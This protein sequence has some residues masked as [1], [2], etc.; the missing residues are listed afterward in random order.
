MKK[1]IEGF[2]QCPYCQQSFEVIHE[3]NIKSLN[4]TAI[5]QCSCDEFPVFDGIVFL[6]KDESLKNKRVVR[7]LKAHQFYK[8]FNLL[9][10]ER[11]KLKWIYK[12]LFFLHA[13]NKIK[14]NWFSFIF[15]LFILLDRHSRDWYKYCLSREKRVV[16]QIC[17]SFTIS[18]TEV[19]K[20][21][22]DCCCG[23]GHF[24][25]ELNKTKTPQNNIGLDYSFKLLFLSRLF[26]SHKKNLL[27]CTDLNNG[28]PFKNKTINS[29]Y[30]N[31]CFMYLFNKKL[32]LMEIERVLKKVGIAFINHVHIKNRKN[33]GEG[34]SISLNL[35]RKISNNLFCF[36]NSDREI[37]KHIK[38]K[39][40]VAFESLQTFKVHKS[41]RSVS[42][43]LKQ[44]TQLSQ[45][46]KRKFI[47]K[48]TLLMEFPSLDYTEE[49]E[50]QKL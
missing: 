42:F 47:L 10:R 12:F 17:K 15:K 13:R 2:L 43:I 4:Y 21:T 27:I 22:V 14:Q 6:K 25:K 16:F 39:N 11:K 45:K 3:F 50:F 37:F 19:K 7:V 9:L 23:L 28:I 44:K 38:Y 20:I 8:A 36:V 29:L 41:H 1:I 5:I 18:S 34:Y 32:I 30:L 46:H 26:I 49:E 35:M 31:D 24:L 40:P 33:I 48:L